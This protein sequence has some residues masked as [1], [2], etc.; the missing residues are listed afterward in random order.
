MASDKGITLIVLQHGLWG[1]QS[2]MNYIE[3]KLKDTLD[4]ERVVILNSDVNEAKY[5]YDGVDICG[6]RL[7]VKI[8]NHVKLLQD[9]NKI[10]DRFIIIGYSLGGLIARYCIGVLGKAGFFDSIEPTLFVTFATPHLGSHRGDASAFSKVYNFVSGRFLSRTGEQLQM[11]DRFND[12]GHPLLVV[13]TDPEREFY[14]YLAKF[15]TRRTYANAINDRTVPYWT[16][17]LDKVNYFAS[18]KNL[19]VSVDTQYTS[20][21]T[22]IDKRDPTE[23]SKRQLEKRKKKKTFSRAKLIRVA[24]V[25]LSPLLPILVL[26]ALSYIG[27]QG[28]VSRLR[29]SR[30]LASAAL[31]VENNNHTLQHQHQSEDSLMSTVGDHPDAQHILLDHKHHDNDENALLMDAL[32]ATNEPPEDASPAEM[33]QTKDVQWESLYNI[34]PSPDVEPADSLGLTDD[35]HTMRDRLLKLEWQRVLVFIKGFNAH[36][37]I[38]C[39]Q[40]RFENSGGRALVQHFVDSVQDMCF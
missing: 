3:T 38:V 6:Q 40:K 8:Q 13:M 26:I 15:K 28:L 4:S 23:P 35:Q 31:V 39:R 34:K 21:V 12:K 19:E 27:V 11:R 36:G 20:I 24:I 1:V 5:T 32:D 37:S 10:V 22:A 29:V 7:A 30:L 18:L 9:K 17:A 16:S 2:H 14:T 25:A 33:R